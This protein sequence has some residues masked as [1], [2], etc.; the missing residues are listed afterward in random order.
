MLFAWFAQRE[1]GSG[2]RPLGQIRRRWTAP[3][4][5]RVTAARV[6]TGNGLSEAGPGSQTTKTTEFK[7][8]TQE[9]LAHTLDTL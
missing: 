4:P 1:H 9:Q 6:V 7:N 8:K 2:L 3:P 5:K